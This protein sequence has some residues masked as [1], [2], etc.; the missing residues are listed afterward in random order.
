MT[1]TFKVQVR[2]IELDPF[3]K[4]KYRITFGNK[5]AMTIIMYVSR[6][7]ART[8]LLGSEHEVVLIVAATE[9]VIA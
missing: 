9:E 8:F 7:V 2:G 3:S 4:D 6:D 5:D 1:T